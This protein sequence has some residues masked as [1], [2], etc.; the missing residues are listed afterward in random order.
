MLCVVHLASHVPTLKFIKYHRKCTRWCRIENYAN[1]IMKIST[2]NYK[3]CKTN[4]YNL[5]KEMGNATTHF[6]R[7]AHRLVM[8]P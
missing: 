5:R 2:L 1:H 8:L 3:E 7:N 6:I 4:I